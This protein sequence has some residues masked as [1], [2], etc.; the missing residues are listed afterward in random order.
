MS[1]GGP[2][3]GPGC[4]GGEASAPPERATEATPVRPVAS[5]RALVSTRIGTRASISTSAETWLGSSGMKSICVTSPTL[6]PLNRTGAP[7]SRPDTDPIEDDLVN[8]LAARLVAAGKPQH[9]AKSGGDHGQGENADQGI[10]RAG[11]HLS[12]LPVRSARHPLTVA[13][14]RL[15]ALPRRLDRRGVELPRPLAMEIGAQPWMVRRQHG[16]DRARSQSLSDPP[17][18]RSGRRPNKG[19]RDHASP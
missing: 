15:G 2:P 19:C 17:A 3:P 12:S 13:P 1:P 9:E 5:S 11:F 4:S 6:T 16:F 18:P 10:I 8:A 14:L 7:R